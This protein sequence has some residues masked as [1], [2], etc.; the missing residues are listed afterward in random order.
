MTILTIKD[1]LV[2]FN[3]RDGEVIA[4]NGLNFSLQ[5]GEVLG[6][7]GESGSGKS[8]AMMS[9]LGLLANNGY[10]QG[11]AIYHGQ[12]LI[13]LNT[14]Q[15]NKIRGNKI[16]MIFQ[17]PMTALNPYLRI[18]TQM[19]EVLQ[20]HQNMSRKSALMAAIAMLESVHIP[21]AAQ[22]IHTYPHQFSGGMRQRVLIAIALL[23]RPDVLIADEPT[24]A[25]DVTVQAQIMRLLLDVKTAQGTAM[26]LI[27]HD[28]G[29][30]AGICDT[31]LVMY[32]GE[33]MEMASVED[34]FA[35]PQ[36]P[37]TQGLLKS[38]PRLDQTSQ[39]LYAIPGQPPIRSN[40]LSG[41][42]FHPRC[43]LVSHRCHVEKPLLQ[44]VNVGH[45]K[46]CHLD[47]PT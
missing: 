18:S 42:P 43:E 28:L 17:D 21:D 11:Q 10:C 7:V 45:T 4:V 22:R 34:L 32:G 27:T 6:I 29:V 5:A 33:I 8:Q 46:A 15:L 36:H 24:T 41:C 30:V 44:A 16:A 20:V 13:T 35:H 3:T 14:A 26:I 9:L 25:L 12:N 31:V 23:C 40:D 38:I 2:R 19:I 37:Y 39:P 47:L 1:L